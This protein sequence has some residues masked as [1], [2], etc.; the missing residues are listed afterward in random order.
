MT[1]RRQILIGA[2]AV[3]LAA[4]L[5]ALPAFAMTPHLDPTVTTVALFESILDS[6]ER[7]AVASDQYVLRF[8]YSD[9]VGS[10]TPDECR[11]SLTD[12]AAV[13]K[14]SIANVRRRDDGMIPPTSG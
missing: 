1:T 8:M 5:P 11:K 6:V 4:A 2:A 13:I 3:P 12:L 9:S 7:A 14:Q 10:R